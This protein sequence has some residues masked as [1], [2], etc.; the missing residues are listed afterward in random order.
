MNE[1][2]ARLT[3]ALAEPLG[4]FVDPGRRV[5]WPGLAVALALAGGLALARGVR[6]RGLAGWLLSPR[7]WAHRSALLDYQII[8]VK[9][10]LRA[11]V[12]APLAVSSLAV[13]VFVARALDGWLEP[14]AHPSWSR[15]QIDAAYTVALFGLSDFSRYL[16]HR[17]LHTVPWLWEIHKVHH[18]AEVLTPLTVYRSHPVEGLLFA[19]R[20]ALVT[21]VVTGVFFHLFRGDLGV[22]D[23][24]GVNA[25]AFAFNLLGSNLRHSHVWLSYGPVV[26]RFLISP[27]QH[28][29]HHSVEPADHHSNLGTC[30]AVWDRLGGSLR[31]TGPRERL[32]FGLREDASN[33]RPDGLLSALLGPLVASIRVLSRRREGA[34]PRR[35]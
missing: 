12:L 35:K 7:I 4:F 10:L 14:S 21:G 29:V 5:F 26:E 24:L 27:A 2:L 25:L 23:V 16:L 15:P 20:G 31:L 34:S 9:A 32:T 18:S 3:A 1:V 30:L 13:T 6:V 22:V 33:H 28:Q 11:S 8:F 19:L 17:W